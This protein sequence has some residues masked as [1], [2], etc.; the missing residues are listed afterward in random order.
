MFS[1]EFETLPSEHYFS[2]L[3]PD[4]KF[5]LETQSDHVQCKSMVLHVI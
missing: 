4:T 1:T 2:S 5:Q 3:V